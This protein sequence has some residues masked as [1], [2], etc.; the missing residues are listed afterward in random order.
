MFAYTR[1]IFLKETDATGV[2]YFGSL[3]QYALEAFEV[4][5]SEKKTPLS[6]ILLQGYLLPIVHAE[7]DYQAPLRVGDQISIELTLGRVGQKSFSIQSKMILL[8]DR[9]EAGKV[10]IVHAFIRKGE[11]KAS[12][13][14]FE[15]LTLLQKGLF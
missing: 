12:E 3:F 13:I 9:K 2:I 10:E 11:D 5:L 15:I 7:A 1:S 6:T 8:P 14:P 4:L